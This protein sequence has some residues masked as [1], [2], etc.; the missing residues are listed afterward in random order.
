M[1]TETLLDAIGSVNDCFITAL[2]EEEP[3]R[4]KPVRRS[5]IGI[6]A[7][8]CLCLIIGG[9]LYM[10]AQGAQSAPGF[11]ITAYAKSQDS[12]NAL[13]RILKLSEPATIDVFYAE[14]GQP[15]FAFSYAAAD[16]NEAASSFYITDYAAKPDSFPAAPSMATGIEEKPGNIYVY[17]L[18]SQAKQAP[19]SFSM[20]QVF[21]GKD[22]A[23][24]AATMLIT[25]SDG[26]YYVEL[27]KMDSK[28]INSYDTTNTYEVYKTNNSTTWIFPGG[29]DAS[30]LAK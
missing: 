25:E 1:N 27:E 6:A 17:Y 18:P 20:I 29:L 3:V 16:P 19:Y 28:A 21:P 24:L 26:Q 22:G 23:S 9:F 12:E 8:A 7:A 2:S 5:R 10:H 4:R 13:G 30:D 14:N 15:I 11:A